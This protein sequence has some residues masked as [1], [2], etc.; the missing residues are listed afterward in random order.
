MSN[1]DQLNKLISDEA[2]NQNKLVEFYIDLTPFM[3][4]YKERNDI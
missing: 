3:L 1:F 2:S 4:M